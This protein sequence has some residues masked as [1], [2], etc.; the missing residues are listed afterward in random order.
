MGIY[1]I[2]RYS[3]DDFLFAIDD[4]IQDELQIRFSCGV[5]HILMDWIFIDF[6]G[7]GM[8]AFNKFSTMISQHRHLGGN[9][10]QHGFATAREA[11]KEMRIN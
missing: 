9:A 3:L 1:T 6:T 5:Q 11:R 10:R 7:S 4:N 2:T 8:L